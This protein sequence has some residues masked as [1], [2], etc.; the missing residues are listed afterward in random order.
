MK[1]EEA[2]YV[3]HSFQKKS[4]RGIATPKHTLDLIAERL[5]VAE[6]LYREEFGAKKT[7][8]RQG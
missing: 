2:V 4:T 7:E 5:K 8:V 1:F 3:L 6:Q